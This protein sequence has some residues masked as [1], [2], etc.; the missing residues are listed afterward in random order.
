MDAAIETDG[1]L[2]ASAR[3]LVNELEAGNRAAADRLIDALGKA[4][5]Q[6]LFREL[7]K[8]TRQLHEALNGFTLDS[9]M[10]ALAESDIP[11]ARMRLNHVITMTEESA[12][13]TLSAVESTLPVAEQLRSQA[14]GLGG[15]WRRFRNKDMT[16]E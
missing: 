12:N 8:M 11:D 16:L 1:E 13:R 10:A 5:E 7:G 15:K 3:A 4:R 14:D 2:L 9:R 6:S